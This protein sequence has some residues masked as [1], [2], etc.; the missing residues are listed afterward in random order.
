MRLGLVGGQDD[1]KDGQGCPE[2]RVE[3]GVGFGGNRE[4]TRPSYR[5]GE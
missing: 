2:R 1:S 4:W 5:R 3:G